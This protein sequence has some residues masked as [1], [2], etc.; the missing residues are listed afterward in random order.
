MDTNDET[1]A[2]KQQLVGLSTLLQLEQQCRRTG[3]QA[4]FS[5]FVVNDTLRLIDYHQAVFWH[6]SGF[7]L[8]IRS[9]SGVDRPNSDSPYLQWLGRVLG[10]L[11]KHHPD[12][13]SQIIT[14]DDLP[15]GLR[16]GW[17]EWMGNEGV[18][19]PF[20]AKGR[21]AAGLWFKREQ[22]WSRAETALLEQ[23]AEAYGHAWQGLLDRSRWFIPRQSPLVRR[24][25]PLLLLLGLLA[26]LALP[27][28]LSVL[29]PARVVPLDPLLVSSP[30]RGVIE[31]FHVRPNQEVER[32]RL[33]FTLDDTELRNRYEVARKALAV[34]EAQLQQATQKSLF[35]RNS[36]IDIDLLKARVAI[37]KAEMQYAADELGR[38]EVRAARA[39]IVVFGDVND[40]IG[41]PVVTGEKILLLADP[42]SRELQ[43]QVPLDNAVNLE[44]GARVRMF[45]HVDPSEAIPA[46]L[47]Q[48]SYEARET[49]QG[50]LAYM[51]KAAFQEDSPKIRIGLQGTAKIYGRET[52]LYYYLLRRPWAALRRNLGI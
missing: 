46:T 27:V 21:P 48:T 50:T 25:L 8:T 43:I 45:L 15:P 16:H 1:K 28:K 34:A 49:A 18:W 26:C 47:M 11:R 5:F 4:E 20:P 37:K 42:G 13:P 22:E 44:P 29:A 35:D 9:V 51:V 40:W 33:L 31:E 32:G 17:R 41:K 52:R 19:C 10:F 36:A 30:L 39:G 3:D 38:V 12:R 14:E 24:F 7:S 6:E 23:L 2:L